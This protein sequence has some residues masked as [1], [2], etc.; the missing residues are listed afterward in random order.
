MARDEQSHQPHRNAWQ[1]AWWRLFL[2]WCACAGGEASSKA[3]RPADRARYTFN[4]EPNLNI[5]DRIMTHL[6]NNADA[7]TSLGRQGGIFNNLHF[8]EPDD[9]NINDDDEEADLRQDYQ[10]AVDCLIQCESLFNT[11]QTRISS[12]E[13]QIALLEEKV[14]SLSL[15]LASV[16]AREDYRRLKKSVSVSDCDGKLK[17]E[18]STM[19]H[20]HGHHHGAATG[21]DVAVRR[22]TWAPGGSSSAGYTGAPEDSIVK[23]L[24][25]N[26]LGLFL[27]K[28]INSTTSSS[29]SSSR[30]QEQQLFHPE[31]PECGPSMLD[32]KKTPQRPGRTRSQDSLLLEL[33]GVVFPV[34]SLDIIRRGCGRSHEQD[35]D[36]DQHHEYYRPWR[37]SHQEMRN[38]EWP[39]F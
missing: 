36:D 30:Q 7:G 25:Q 20:H 38:E 34:S 16:K 12:Y 11:F 15:E 26:Y 19:M 13:E 35:D 4:V 2:F 3:A 29:A 39:S 14:M 21:R 18:D 31:E 28:N 32:S 37:K 27:R 6:C 17:M 5:S 23:K 1:D 9:N 24:T 33:D 8:A 22:T 10:S